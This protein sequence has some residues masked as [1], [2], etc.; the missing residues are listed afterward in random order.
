VGGGVHSSSEG[1]GNEKTRRASFRAQSLPDREVM[2]VM[3][4]D[5]A[6]EKGQA[7]R[8]VAATSLQAATT[9][10]NGTAPTSKGVDWR[11]AGALHAAFVAC[12]DQRLKPLVERALS[13]L[14]DALRIFGADATF[15]SF[16]G[17]KDACVILHLLRAASFAH[18]AGK[19]GLVY[20]DSKD[21]FEEIRTL[22]R[23]HCAAVADELAVEK[24]DPDVSFV[25]GLT[26]IVA[27][28][29]PR[30][31]AFVLGTRKGDPNCGTQQHFEPS[32]DW[33]PPFMRV[34]PILDW[35]YHDVWLFLRHFHLP[36]C[37]L[38]DQ[39]Y[40]SLGSTQNT[41]Q[42]PALL[43]SDGTYR[44][45]YELQDASLE[46]AGRLESPKRTKPQHAP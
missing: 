36:Y 22:V 41:Q 30:G 44:P 32:S 13:R 24:I 23:E 33:M 7:Q 27:R 37:H 8:K 18:N 42:N 15:A 11:D 4:L 12:E 46:R 19:P 21:E 29:K 14:K 39:G 35:S 28:F 43:R 16:N 25:A 31:L 6:P 40:T 45:A 38:Y 20:F 2:S 26:D 3:P 5:A 1:T 10:T 9:T 34:N 17:G